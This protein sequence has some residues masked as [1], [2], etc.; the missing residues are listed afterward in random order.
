MAADLEGM[1][2]LL[3]KSQRHVVLAQS[4]LNRY[5]NVWLSGWAENTLLAL[6]LVQCDV[7]AAVE[8]GNAALA[9]GLESGA[10][11][12]IRHSYANLGRL[13]YTTGDFPLALNYLRQAFEMTQENGE[14]AYA[15][16]DSMARVSMAQ[17]QLSE[18]EKLTAWVA[19]GGRD[20]IWT[21]GYI[22]RHSLLTR[23]E[24]L[25]R[26][27]GREA[28]ARECLSKV[29]E[30]AQRCGD[31]LLQ[32]SALLLAEETRQVDTREGHPLSVSPR[33]TRHPTPDSAIAYERALMCRLLTSG[34]DQAASRHFERAI[35]LA[36]AVSNR[37]AEGD[38]ERSWGERRGEARPELPAF[39]AQSAALQD[40]AS[41]L[42]HAGRPELLA[43]GLIAIIQTTDCIT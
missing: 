17:G 33:P 21:G 13:R 35:R 34:E 12:V 7:P 3:A 31:T 36:R 20:P 8:H 37:P 15:I 40:F 39:R 42:M 16:M 32:D 4:I 26:L 1:R 9:L 41:L 25:G 14:A 10:A 2:G 27:A 5:P 19:G 6:S 11:A 29:L 22:Y 28:E 24:I 30:Y 43:T 18:A 38:V 23:A